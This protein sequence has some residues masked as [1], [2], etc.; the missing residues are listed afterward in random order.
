MDIIPLDQVEDDITASSNTMPDVIPL[1]QVEDDIPIYKKFA[2]GVLSGISGLGDLASLANDYNPL[3]GGRLAETLAGQPRPESAGTMARNIFDKATGLNGS[4]EVGPDSYVYKAGEYLPSVMMSGPSLFATGVKGA[5]PA[6]AKLLAKDAAI[7]G[8]GYVGN[9]IAG[10][11]GEILGSVAP[12]AAVAG[13]KGIASLF[14]PAAQERTANAAAQKIIADIADTKVA[15][16]RLATASLADEAAPEIIKAQQTYLPQYLRTAEI[17]GQPGIASLEKTLINTNPEV[18]SFVAEQ[19]AAREAARQSI[20]SKMAPAPM[21]QEQAGLAIREG[22]TANADT[23]G[24]K[25]SDLAAKAFIGGEELAPKAAKGVVTA[26]LNQFTKDGARTVSGEFRDLV[27]NFRALPSKVD[28]QTLQNYRSSFGEWA[29]A[30]AAQGASTVE[31]QTAR[32]AGAMR[33]ALDKSIEKA[34]MSGDLPASQANAWKKMIAA[35]SAQGDLYQSGAVGD[36]L[37][38]APFSSAT[39]PKFK[40]GASEITDKSLSSVEDARQLVAALNKQSGGIKAARGAILSKIWDKST[41]IT[42]ANSVEFNAAT[43]NRQVKTLADVSKEVL[44]PSQ[45][46]GLGIIADDLANQAGVGRK[47]YAASAG[48]SITAQSTSNIQKIQEAIS[49]Q[50]P[51][52]IRNAIKEI[53]ILGRATD[54]L[55]NVVSNPAQRQ[56]LVNKALADFIMDPA[57]AEALLVGNF[58]PKTKVLQE[59]GTFLQKSINGAVPGLAAAGG[60]VGAAMNQLKS[61]EP[62]QAPAKSVPAAVDSLKGSKKADPVESILDAIKHVESRGNPKAVSPKGAQGAYQIMPEMQKR[63]GVKDATNE[64]DARAGAKK[65]FLDELSYFKDPKLAMAAYN[66]GRPK[67]LKAGWKPGMSFEDIVMN[68]PAETRNYVPQVLAQ[69]GQV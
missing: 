38:K 59:F 64:K 51:G 18:R 67:L 12:S 42:G 65:L 20:F 2:S 48:Q 33:D 61:K 8:G 56:R 11:P 45:V 60:E 27:Q 22:L 57:K 68:L 39:N 36:I 50:A 16:H 55:L 25:V 44:T 4:T 24:Q 17:T 49:A 30:G 66:L 53:P 28:L 3:P 6:I 32:V 26:T 15:N 1:D 58:S 9:E 23:A 62:Q 29:G 5:I 54:T 31:K 46:K 40:I 52:A 34:V 41:S 21:T 35:R 14:S 7:S 37:E 13:V 63:L 10:L 43:F 69:L 47:A 19:N